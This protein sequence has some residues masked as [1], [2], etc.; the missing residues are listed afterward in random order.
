MNNRSPGAVPSTRDPWTAVMYLPSAGT[1]TR[2]RPARSA[3]WR[4]DCQ[5]MTAHSW[6]RRSELLGKDEHGDQVGDEHDGQ[7]ETDPVVHAAGVGLTGGEHR[8][9]RGGPGRRRHR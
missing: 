8:R 3:T 1:V 2:R 9:L 5:L 7:S 4:M 6:S